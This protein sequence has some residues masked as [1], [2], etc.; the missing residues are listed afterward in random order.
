MIKCDIMC[1]D[2]WVWGV[3]RPNLLDIFSILAYSLYRH[4]GKFHDFRTSFGFYIIYK[5]FS[6]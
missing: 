4:P 2:V 1:G 3:Q 6:C 5:H